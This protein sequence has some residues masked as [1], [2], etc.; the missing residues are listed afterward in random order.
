MT[1]YVALLRGINVGTH[2]RVA[3][4]DVR[5][6]LSTAGHHGVR[7]H[8][9]SGNVI[10]ESPVHKG[11]VLARTIEGVLRRELDLKADVLVRSATEL[12]RVVSG[13]PFASRG[14]DPKTLHV[15]FLKTRPAG[16]AVKALD[17]AEFGPDEFRLRGAEIYLHY[18]AGT[19]RSK[20]SAAFFERALGAPVTV[21]NW[22]VVTRL[23]ELA[24]SNG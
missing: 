10:L 6:A 12:A 11:E 9:Q 19:A 17:G 21:R 16:A 22:Q 15:A 8:L 13:N 7:T 24:S 18:A 23:L 5:G 2:Q 14:F 20:M 1:W 4:A 3:M